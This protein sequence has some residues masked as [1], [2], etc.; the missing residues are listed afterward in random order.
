MDDFL[1]W[2]GMVQSGQ[3]DDYVPPQRRRR[4]AGVL[5]RRLRGL[6]RAAP[7]HA[8]RD[9]GR[10]RAGGAHPGREPLAVAPARHL[11]R[12]HRARARR[13]REGEPRHPAGRAALVLRPCRDHHASATST[14]S[15]R[16]AAASPCSIAWPSRASTSSS[17]TAP[18]RA[19][20]TPPIAAHA[21]GRRAR[22]GAGTDATRVASYNPWVSLSWLVT[23][24]T[25]GGARAL[26][27]SA[28]ASTARTALRLWTEEVDLVLQRGRP[29]RAGSRPGQLADLVVL[30]RR[31]SCRARRARSRT[32]PRC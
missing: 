14:A 6:P 17:A 8:A 16:S 11:R 31:L 7:G 15:P 1:R 4:D 3:G 5:G 18:R 10:A 22:V 28:T 26:S 13:V 19:E 9:G 20:T 32:S 21:R 29:A 27:R 24:R 25:V 23:G 2:T 30:D 12:D